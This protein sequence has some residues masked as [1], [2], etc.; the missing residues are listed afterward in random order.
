MS[1]LDFSR[2]ATTQMWRWSSHGGCDRTTGGRGS[3]H[4][5][6]QSGISSAVEPAHAHAAP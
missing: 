1:S 6:S 5:Q 4:I 3:F 2:G